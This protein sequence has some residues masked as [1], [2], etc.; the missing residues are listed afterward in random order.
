[1]EFR[2]HPQGTSPWAG[3]GQFTSGIFNLSAFN[4]SPGAYTPAYSVLPRVDILD[5]EAHVIYLFELPGAEPDKLSL[6]ISPS[7]VALNAP[8]E[9]TARFERA[10]FLYQE[11]PKGTYA[12][13]LTPPP[14]VD[15][16]NVSA[17]YRYGLLEV[18]F[19]KK[20]RS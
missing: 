16:D 3:A 20:Q 10:A 17:D 19:P 11:R 14:N 15:L 6:E 8:M 2:S 13:L 12:R 5:T 18:R 9:T 7:E 4:Y 1:M